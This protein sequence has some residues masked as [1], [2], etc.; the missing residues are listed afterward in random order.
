ML[1]VRM[2]PAAMIRGLLI[3]AGKVTLVLTTG[4]RRAWKPENDPACHGDPPA[5]GHCG[6]FKRRS[7]RQL[8][9]LQAMP[10]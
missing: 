3:A 9:K 5:P 4:G 2:N 1:V 7:K 10:T 8:Q 6:R